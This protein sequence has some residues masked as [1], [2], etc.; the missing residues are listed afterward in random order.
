M[1]TY[2][3]KSANLEKVN[4]EE[5]KKQER[6]R[7]VFLLLQQ[8]VEREEITLKLIVD[9]LYDVGTVNII[10][11]KYQNKP[12]NRFLKAIA[13]TSKPILRAV[14]LRWLKKKLPI[15]LTDWLEGKV[16]FKDD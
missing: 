5:L 9:C 13:N 12:M 1:L 15:L 6:M 11:K 7:D 3:E 4:P 10:N 2:P 14:A 8:L 16:S